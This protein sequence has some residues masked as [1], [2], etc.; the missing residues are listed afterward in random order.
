MLTVTYLFINTTQHDVTTPMKR[1]ARAAVRSL[2]LRN[3]C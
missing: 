1:E 2:W 3:L